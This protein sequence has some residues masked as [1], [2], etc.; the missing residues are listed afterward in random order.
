M[1]V[2]VALRG[3]VARSSASRA[4]VKSRAAAARAGWTA[5]GLRIV[6]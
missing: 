1:A 6:D 4:A 5:S 2:G 3:G